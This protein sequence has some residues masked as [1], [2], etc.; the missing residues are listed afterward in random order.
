MAYD[1]VKFFSFSLTTGTV[2][3]G[4]AP[5]APS[6]STQGTLGSCSAYRHTLFG[7]PLATNE[8]PGRA[9]VMRSQSTGSQAHPP[10]HRCPADGRKARWV[11]GIVDVTKVSN[12]PL[13]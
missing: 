12:N 3:T 10:G 8:Q 6:P 13:S 5:R 9:H 7:H 2:L 11:V 4:R 1:S